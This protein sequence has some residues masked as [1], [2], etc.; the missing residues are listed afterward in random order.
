MKL[1]ETPILL[2]AVLAGA[3]M[4]L[5]AQTPSAEDLVWQKAIQKYDAQRLSIL[6]QLD[7]E[8]NAGPFQPTWDSLKGYQIPEWYQ[9]AKF[10]IFIHWGVYA[11]PAFDN[12]WYPRNMYLE[13]NKVFKH[14]VETYGP[15]TQF[16]YKDFIPQFKAGKFDPK[17]WA[18]LFRR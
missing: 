18:D 16:G 8:A 9:N 6:K 2:S 14:H 7:K 13:G 12:E 17:T 3:S 1:T 10:G 11:V 15:Q 5:S 4:L